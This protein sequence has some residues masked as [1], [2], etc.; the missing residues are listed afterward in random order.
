MY[1]ENIIGEVQSPVVKRIINNSNKVGCLIEV[2]FLSNQEELVL[3]TD[4][5]YQD[6]VA[7]CIYL[8]IIEYLGV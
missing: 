5:T 6:R 2:G 8:G 3:L 1:K 4:K 7:Y